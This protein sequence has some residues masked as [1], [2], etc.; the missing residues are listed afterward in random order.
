MKLIGSTILLLAAVVSRAQVID[1]YPFWDGNVT[2]GWTAIAQTFDAPGSTLTDYQFGIDGNSA[3]G[4]LNISLY[5]WVAGTGQTGAALYSTSVAWPS[6]TGD[7][8][9]SG[10][11]VAVTNGS[12]YGMIVEL[13]GSNALSVHYMGNVTGSPTG[14][15]YW[16]GDNGSTWSG[17]PGLSTK[18][19]ATFDPVPEPA[20][21]AVLGLGALALVCRRRKN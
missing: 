18:F 10:I 8:V 20:T 9:L 3:G 5:N 14:Y 6:S 7:I 13:G 16:S 21:F 15:G 17:I 19:R 4:T 12:H 2:N 1:T 11:N